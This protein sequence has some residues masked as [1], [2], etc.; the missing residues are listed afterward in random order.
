MPSLKS[1]RKRIS[2]VKSTQKI[3]RA[4]KMVAGAK[5]NKAQ[6]RITELRPYAV[7]VQEVLWEITRDAGAALSADA[8][9]AERIGAEGE[10]AV[11]AG[12]AT[13]AH[14]L[15]VTRP[16]R[17]VLLL[18]LTSDRG[19]CGAFNTNI[20]K[21]AEREWKSR[22]EAGQEVHLAIIGRKGRDY[23]NR[24]NA[25]IREYLP[26]VWDKLGLET[27]QAVGAKILAPF[28]KDEI[29]AIYLV[30]NEFKS[31]I[32]QTVV[33][34]RLL[35]AGAPA[36]SE[37]DE[38]DRAGQAAEFLFEPD[39]GALLERLVP[40]Y[41]DISVLRALHESMASELGAKLTAMDAANKNAKEMI[42]SLTLE[43]NKARQAAITKELMEIIGGSEALKE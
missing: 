28:N 2:S 12:G 21:R 27:A 40:M 20:N 22:T 42:D 43:Y 9:A 1:I 7:K 30:Y 41:V 16:E 5:L 37:A 13:P 35:P 3:T 39:R 15:L 4:M 25:P 11:L 29:D 8:P 10:A 6:Q 33:V 38:G 31:A 24:R 36:R 14:P 18:V 34:E 23:F 32:T 26:G 17:R 19:L